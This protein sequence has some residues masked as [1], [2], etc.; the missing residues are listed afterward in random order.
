[1]KHFSRAVVSVIAFSVLLAGCGIQGPTKNIVSSYGFTAPATTLATITYSKPENVPQEDLQVQSVYGGNA[2]DGKARVKIR[3]NTLVGVYDTKHDSVL[4]MATATDAKPR[5]VNSLTTATALITPFFSFASRSPEIQKHMQDLAAKDT[6]VQGLATAIDAAV[7]QHGYWQVDDV[8]KELL[9]AYRSFSLT[10]ENESGKRLS[11]ERR[12]VASLVPVSF[13]LLPLTGSKGKVMMD[14]YDMQGTTLTASAN[15]SSF[16]YQ[17]LNS[18]DGTTNL[19]YS[20][21]IGVLSSSVLQ[22][23]KNA[24]WN[25]VFDWGKLAIPTT[26]SISYAVPEGQEKASFTASPFTTMGEAFTLMDMASQF[27]SINDETRVCFNVLNHR[28]ANWWKA[29]S[30][31][32]AFLQQISGKSIDQISKKDMQGMVDVMKGYLDDFGE[33][34]AECGTKAAEKY[35]ENG[36]LKGAA[37][38]FGKTLKVLTGEPKDLKIL[39][40][41]L[42]E[43]ATLEPTDFQLAVKWRDTAVEQAQQ[44]GAQ[45]EAISLPREEMDAIAAKKYASYDLRSPHAE[46]RNNTV[47]IEENVARNP[48]KMIT[49]DGASPSCNMNVDLPCHDG[50]PTSCSSATADPSGFFRIFVEKTCGGDSQIWSYTNYLSLNSPEMQSKNHMFV[51]LGSHPRQLENGRLIYLDPQGVI[52]EEGKDF[53]EKD[54]IA[55]DSLYLYPKLYKFSVGGDIINQRQPT[56]QEVAEDTAWQ[57]EQIAKNPDLYANFGPGTLHQYTAEAKFLKVTLLDTAGKKLA[58][59]LTDKNGAFNITYEEKSPHKPDYRLCVYPQQYGDAEQPMT[60]EQSN[61]I[62]G[63]AL[64][65]AY[66]EYISADTTGKWRESWDGKSY[67]DPHEEKG[68]VFKKKDGDDS[69]TAHVQRTFVISSDDKK[70]TDKEWFSPFE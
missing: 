26:T 30:E 20:A 39:Q 27:I 16:V 12:W 22:T 53:N 37:K 51:G 58:E 54:F 11:S 17:E 61:C 24:T 21:D 15:N 14:N 62:S 36:F 68:F 64:G 55:A 8:Q 40:V 46:V 5:E 70:L 31:G 25:L 29:Y 45:E 48:K 56:D 50:L 19:L 7:A 42:T 34:M 28:K 43:Y 52:R 66:N 49:P 13:D 32:L 10:L 59:T 4:Y 35:V 60:I 23:I 3:K 9:A 18:P 63:K 47:Y 69:L 57:K 1:M 6:A 38:I 44:Q 2:E 67:Y 41:V 65:G 33:L